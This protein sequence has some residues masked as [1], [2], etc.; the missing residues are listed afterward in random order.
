VPERDRAAA[1]GVLPPRALR[2]EEEHR[3]LLAALAAAPVSVLLA[4]RSDPR[5]QRERQPAPWFLDLVGAR[6]GH[7]VGTDELGALSAAAPWLTDVASFE[8]GVVGASVPAGADE[9][10]LAD[11]VA[12]H[13][14]GPAV[15]TGVV[16]AEDSALRRG[17]EAA[18]ARRS[19]AFDQWSG[20]VGDHPDLLVGLDRPRSPTGLER[21]AI[22]PFRSFLG[23]VLYVGAVDDPTEA[24]LLSALDEGSLVHE[25]LERFIDGHVG[26]PPEEAWSDDERTEMARIADEVADRYEGEGRTGRPLLWGVRRAQIH[27]QLQRF[28]DRDEDYRVAEGVSPAAVELA[29][30]L[31]SD[32]GE[33]APVGVDLPGGRRLAFKGIVDRVDRSPDGRRIVVSDYKTG[34]PDSFRSIAPRGAVPDLTARGTKLQLPIYALAAR[35]RF[36]GEAVDSVDA[37]YWFVGPRGEGTMIGG[38]YDE[39]ADRRFRQVVTTV[40]DGIEAGQFP[41]NPGR[42]DYRFGA[43]THENC[44]WCDYDRVCPTTRGEAWVQL[45][46][47]PEL[48]AY[49]ALAEEQ[50]SAEAAS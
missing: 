8:A 6:A 29:F 39:A 33:P 25:V 37:R 32:P 16:A 1:G 18:R 41:A 44:S 49:V 20:R 13:R 3:D 48:G 5:E 27:H 24:E 14:T 12:D 7:I 47:A 26:K 11:L 2:R 35:A 50:A 4:P 43:W 28:L 36:G 34:K 38:E 42:E 15:A 40:V 45:R 10:D 9:L 23:D 21:Y 22:C 17:L 30:G 46:R 19:G 31:E